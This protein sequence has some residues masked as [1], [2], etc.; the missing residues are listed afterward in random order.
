[1]PLERSQIEPRAL[2]PDGKPLRLSP[3]EGDGQTVTVVDRLAGTSGSYLIVQAEDKD[4]LVLLS[5]STVTE[6]YEVQE[7]KPEAS[8]PSTPPSLSGGDPD[9]DSDPD[10]PGDKTGTDKSSSTRRSGR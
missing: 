10:S 9:G 6:K 3:R 5:E 2:D 7:S 1:M 8:E 4:T